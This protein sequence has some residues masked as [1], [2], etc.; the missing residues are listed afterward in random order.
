MNRYY[1]RGRDIEMEGHE[2]TFTRDE[3]DTLVQQIDASNNNY[4]TK[5]SHSQNALNASLLQT[6][7]GLLIAIFVQPVSQITSIQIALC[8]FVCFLIGLELILFAM[9]TVKASSST[10]K[11]GKSNCTTTGLNN[12]SAVL[13]YILMLF[14]F[15]VLGLRSYAAI[16]P[17]DFSNVNQTSFI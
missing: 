9:L 10:E 13:S 4:A 8:V 6:Q 1:Q 3:V 12:W 7:V 5:Q 14:S 17:V 2:D 15:V 11:I 16:S